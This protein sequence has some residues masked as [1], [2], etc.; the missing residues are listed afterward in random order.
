MV[1]NGVD[2]MCNA[3][4]PES[5]NYC[6]EEC[7]KDPQDQ[8]LD[9]SVSRTVTMSRFCFYSCEPQ[10]KKTG[11]ACAE[12]SLTEQQM[13]ETSGGNGEDL[14]ELK[15]KTG[16]EV[17]VLDVDSE[18]DAEAAVE[19]VTETKTETVEEVKEENDTMQIVA[20]AQGKEAQA[21]AIEARAADAEVKTKRNRMIAATA[22]S[23]A[24]NAAKSDWTTVATLDG[25]ESQSQTWAHIS[26]KAAGFAADDLAGIRDAAKQAAMDAA[27]VATAEMQQI[28]DEASKKAAAL[29]AKFNP[30]KPKTAEAANRVVAPYNAAM[31][32][33]MGIRAQYSE[34]AQSLSNDAANLQ[35]NAR[36]L[37]AQAAAYQAGG[38][39]KM[40]GGMMARAKGMLGQAAAMDAEAQQFQAV[41]ASITQQIP[42]YQFAAAAAA[43][44]ATALANPAGQPPPPLPMLT[45]LR[46]SR[47]RRSS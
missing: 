47:H 26:A 17:D 31:G 29:K 35:K 40:A 33:A 42:D 38:N 19:P 12:L 13:A 25:F 46:S 27:K 18:K 20:D 23:N 34:K 2:M 16:K 4:P 24:V 15:K 21:S 10:G 44:R 1:I 45:Q 6:A 22:A 9:S 43:A 7:D 14:A 30:P 41:A 8:I 36:I 32:R 39:T 3:A 28:A 5:E 37:A 11:E